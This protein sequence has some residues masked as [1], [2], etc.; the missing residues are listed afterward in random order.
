MFNLH[1]NKKISKIFLRNFEAR[2]PNLMNFHTTDNLRYLH[3]FHF[4]ASI[5]ENE[6]THVQT[7]HM[8]KHKFWLGF[9]H[10]VVCIL[11]FYTTYWTLRDFWLDTLNQ[12]F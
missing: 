1:M 5:R 12:Y 8:Y 6:T 2:F 7:L 10:T 11:S 3:H 4:Y 9:V